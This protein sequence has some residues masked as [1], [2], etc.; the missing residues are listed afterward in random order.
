[1]RVA[2]V[3]SWNTFTQREFSQYVLAYL[4]CFTEASL[5]W[6]YFKISRFLWS[7]SDE[8]IKKN[9]KEKKKKEVL[10]STSLWQEN[11]FY[12]NFSSGGMAETSERLLL[13]CLFFLFSNAHQKHAQAVFGNWRCPVYLSDHL[14][15]IIMWPVGLCGAVPCSP[16]A[17]N[18][19]TRDLLRHADWMGPAAIFFCGQPRAQTRG[20]EAPTV[21]RQGVGLLPSL[22]IWNSSSI[23]HFPPKLYFNLNTPMVGE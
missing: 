3:Y 19:L 15:L 17:P 8:R 5:Y 1:M 10:K 21:P 12:S 20:P 2:F 11:M 23:C 13:L 9:K 4:R 6:C 18:T 22:S 14:Q 16:S 7:F